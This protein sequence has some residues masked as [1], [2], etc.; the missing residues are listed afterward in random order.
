MNLPTD[1]EIYS[2]AIADFWFDEEGIFY[3]IAKPTERNIENLAQAYELVEKITAGKKVCLLTDL[4][5]TG[6][7]SKKERDF[8]ME[9]LPRYY[10]VMAI[11]TQ[12]DF[13][14]TIANIFLSL[15]NS[16]I[17]IKTFKTEEE[18]KEWI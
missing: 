1:R 14:R 15:Y 9:L 8:A 18:A 6:V 17:P 5:N 7:Q 10:K 16:P 12:S 11:I 2:S 3:C 13:G 4:T